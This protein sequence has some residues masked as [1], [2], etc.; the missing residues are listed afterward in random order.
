MKRYIIYSLL[1]FL[2]LSACTEEWLEPDPKSFFSPESSLVDK[3]GMEALIVS[4]NKRYRHE[5][6]L[7]DQHDILGEWNYSDMSIN[8]APPASI[9][10]NMETQM[11]PTSTDD[12]EVSS[13]WSRA[14]A[15][16]KDANII[17]SRIDDVEFS[18]EADKNE[19]L[20]NG[21]FSRAYW[22][23][24]LVHQFGDVPLL[25]EEV[26]SP[27]LDFYTHTRETILKQIAG[28]LEFAVQWLPEDVSPGKINGAAGS[29]L[30]TKCYLAL[31]EFDKAIA[32]ASKIIDGG[33]YHLMTE[34]FGTTE[35]EFYEYPILNPDEFDVIWD[36]HQKNNKSLAENKEAIF[37]VQDEYLVEGGTER[38]EG[39]GKMRDTGPTW[40]HSAVLDPNGARGTTDNDYDTGLM[41]IK[42]LGRGVGRMIPCQ[43]FRDM[44]WEDTTDIRY[45]HNNYF[46][47]ERY[48]YN[49]PNSD[50]YGQ[51][52]NGN[53]ITDIRAWYPIM[54]NKLVYIDDSKNPKPNGA[55][56]D[57]YVYRLAEL[58]LLR[59][60]AY[61]WKGDIPNATKDVNTVRARAQ[62][63]Q[64][65]TVDIDYIFDERARELYWETPRKCELTRVAYIM[66]QLGQDGYSLENMHENNWFYDRVMRRNNF[67]RDEVLNVSNI[68][69][70]LPYH[71]YWPIKEEVIKSNSLG[72]INQNMGYPGSENNISPL[73]DPNQ[74][75]PN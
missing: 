65:E 32:E 70:M 34:R 14:W 74:Q 45:S 52:F 16:I 61:W 8:G 30:L 3:A 21:Y 40:W 1:I 67:Y 47:M 66:A 38:G 31:R 27:R 29:F 35:P 44:R 64:K 69:R 39:A 46:G 13:Y 22:Y 56:S 51:S 72:H 60:E 18:S 24:R 43:F 12:K 9:M 48:I 25:L 75:K 7:T 20:A 19:I 10:H 42:Q 62:A 28:D 41:M 15:G 6:A 68:Y 11:T 59:A 37:V 71:V 2:I 57:M 36:L 55:W 58:Y 23:Y 33:K 49:N 63:S 17:I 54:Y 5:Y 73:T 26:T 4:I 53:F 50:Y